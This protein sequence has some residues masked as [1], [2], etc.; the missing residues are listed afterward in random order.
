MSVAHCVSCAILRHPWLLQNATD[1]SCDQSSMADWAVG[2]D[3]PLT[4]NADRSLSTPEPGDTAMLQNT[5][6]CIDKKIPL[7]SRYDNFINGGWVAPVRGQYFVNTSPVDGKPLC[8]IARSSAEDIEL[9]LDAAHAAADKWGPLVHHRTLQYPAQDCRPHGAVCQ[10]HRRRGNRR[11]RQAD[12]RNQRRRHPAGHRPL[13]LLRRLHP[14]SGRLD[15]R[16]RRQH[17][18]LPLPRAAGRG[19]SDH[20]VELPAAD[21]RLENWPR[22]W[23]Q[24]TAWCSSRQNK[25][26]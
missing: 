8:E 10:L 3:N 25:P 2:D 13:P 23:W 20:P 7:R 14:R 6:D 12:P 5:L 16:N 9:A 21:G 19:R 15:L 26:R 4:V 22:P 17:R 1:R 11:Q 24:A 18:G